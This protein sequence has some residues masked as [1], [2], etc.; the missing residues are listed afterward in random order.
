VV[1]RLIVL[2]ALR[3]FQELT[4]VKLISIDKTK[5]EADKVPHKKEN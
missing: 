1:L 2:M 3:K 5:S 4:F